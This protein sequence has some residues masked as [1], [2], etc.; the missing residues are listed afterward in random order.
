LVNDNETV[1]ALFDWTVSDTADNVIQ[2]INQDHVT[3]AD[4]VVITDDHIT[5]GQY[6]SLITLGNYQYANDPVEVRYSL[7]EALQ[8]IDEEG[9]ESLNKDPS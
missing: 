3:L 5:Y 8:V 6:Q 2:A 4:T 1:Q 7:E 9:V